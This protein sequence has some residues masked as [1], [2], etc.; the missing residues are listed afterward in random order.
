MGLNYLN[1]LMQIKF[2]IIVSDF[3]NI[4]DMPSY[5]GP[6]RSYINRYYYN[7]RERRCLQF[8]YG[9]CQGN[10]NN[11]ETIEKCQQEC[12]GTVVSG[13]EEVGTTPRPTPVTVPAQSDRETCKLD[14]VYN[15]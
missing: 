3:M 1:Q 10:E 14:I 4:C 13:K 6:C 12:M 7:P 2:Y 5:T 11:F 9:G 8:V 15:S